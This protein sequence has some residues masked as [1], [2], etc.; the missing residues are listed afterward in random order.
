[1]FYILRHQENA[2]QNYVATSSYTCHNQQHVQQLML[3]RMWNKGNIPPF[4]NRVHTC[5]VTMG[6]KFPQKSIFLV[7]QKVEDPSTSRPSYSTL[8]HIP[9]GHFILPQG[10]LFLFIIVLLIIARNWK[11][12]RYH[13]T[14]ITKTTTAIKTKTNKESVV[15][16]HNA[17]ITHFKKDTMKCVGNGWN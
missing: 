15:Y 3:I 6:I 10:Y 16:L 12:P 4:L 7:L 8:A 17:I 9:K 5:N 1:V 2:N 14:T 13:S 11:Q